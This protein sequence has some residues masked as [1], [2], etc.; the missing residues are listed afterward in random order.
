MYRNS[1]KNN[2]EKC[3]LYLDIF[4]CVKICVFHLFF[5]FRHK[6][7]VSTKLGEMGEI[8]LGQ[9]MLLECMGICVLS[10]AH[11]CEM[12][13]SLVYLLTVNYLFH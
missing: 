9:P 8:I 4:S 2:E 1:S 5:A 13:G 3:C 11:E 12:R 10:A 7:L 6:M